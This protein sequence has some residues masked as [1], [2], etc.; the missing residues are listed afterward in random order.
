M[1]SQG[2]TL[3]LGFSRFMLMSEALCLISFPDESRPHS[4][5]QLVAETTLVTL[6]LW[7]SKVVVPQLAISP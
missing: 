2:P 5:T 1:A 6:G 7:S 4:G 3:V